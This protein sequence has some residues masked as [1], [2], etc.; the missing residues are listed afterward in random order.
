MI[1]I[2]STRYSETESCNIWE[3][4]EASFNGVTQYFLLGNIRLL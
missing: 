3:M 4:I 1:G 2:A